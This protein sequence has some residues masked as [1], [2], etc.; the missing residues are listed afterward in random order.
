MTMLT[1]IVYPVFVTGIAQVAFPEKADGSLLRKDGKIMGS[2][3]I[4]QK[5]D[6]P[7]YFWSRP[8]ATDYNPIPSG[9]SNLG[10]TSTKLVNQV[11][12]RKETFIAGNALKDTTTIPQ[13][14]LFASGSGLD[15]HISVDAALLQVA[16]IARA[17]Q[18]NTNQERAIYDLVKRSIEKRQY[19]LLGEERINV[20]L[21]NIGLDGIK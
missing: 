11:N 18:L 10:P 14:M 1:G 20:F 9:A 5:F 4:G 15:P 13:E 21:L 12:E 3:L 16:R 8:S 2:A 6:S 19:G 7:V 17:R